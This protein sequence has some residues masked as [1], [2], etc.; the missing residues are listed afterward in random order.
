MFKKK[1][2]S[3]A[4]VLFQIP[5]S[6]IATHRLFGP[7]LSIILFTMATATATAVVAATN[8]AEAQFLEARKARTETARLH[9]ERRRRTDDLQDF[10]VAFKAFRSAWTRKLKQIQV[11]VQVQ[12]EHVDTDTGASASE[13]ACVSIAVA[14]VVSESDKRRI[15]LE[16]CRLQ[17]ELEYRR[18]QCFSHNSNAREQQLQQL[19]IDSA[20]S[21]PAFTLPAHEL[22]LSDL[23]LLHAEF[24]QCRAE[25]DRKRNHLLP[26]GKFVFSRYRK[27]MAMQLLQGQQEEDADALVTINSNSYPTTTELRLLPV[28]VAEP[29]PPTCMDNTSVATTTLTARHDSKHTLENFSNCEIQVYTGGRVHVVSVCSK[30]NEDDSSMDMNMNMNMNIQLEALDSAPLVLSNI[31]NSNVVM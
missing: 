25:L 21:F 6:N 20:S 13:S 15:H 28:S 10:W 12:G 9:T 1:E 3:L 31:Q 26:K 22:P 5:R 16:F 11:Q 14:V 8:D 19:Q 24:T 23:R 30:K 27:A 2:C 4:F 18:K 7:F 29:E 17:D